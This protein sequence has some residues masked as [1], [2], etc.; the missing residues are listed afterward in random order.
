MK[1]LYYGDNLHVLRDYIKDESVDLIYLDPP[2]NS[3]RDYNLL[4]K[5]PKPPKK[6]DGKS[7]IKAEEPQTEYADASI[8]AFED[9]WHWGQQAED[10][11]REILKCGNTDVA[12]LIQALR[13]FLKENDMM[14]YLVMMCNRLL[15]L[16]RVL[17]STGS[18]YLHCDPT[19]SHYLK[20]VL[21]GVFGKENYRNEISWRRSQPKSHTSV[22]FANCRDIILR[23][24]KSDKVVFNKVFGDHDESYIEQFYRYTDAD[25]R[26]Y[27]LGD[28]TNPNKNRPNLTYEF[29]G[30]TR[31][32]RWTKERM[33]KAYE[34]GLVYQS[35]PGTVPQ[36]KRYL[37]EMGGQPISDDWD[38]IE[39]LHGSNAEFMGYPTQK[40][41]VLLDRIISASSNE[42]DVVLDPF[43]GCGTAVHAAEKLKRQ[44]IGI[45]ITHLAVSLIEKRMKEAFPYLAN[46]EAFEIIGTPQDLG[47]ARDLAERDKHQ[48]QLWACTLVGAQPYKGG[49]KGADGGIDGVLWIEVGGAGK[50]SQTE[51]V[52]VQVKGGIHVNRANI[53][54]LKGDIDREKAAIGL[55]ITLTEPTQPMKT[56][57]AA[58]GHWESPVT[59]GDRQDFPRIQ[60][61][62]I[63]GLLSG[64]ERPQFPDLSRGEQTFK[65]AKKEKKNQKQ[66][67]LF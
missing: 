51:K 21:D 22:N 27:R 66:A 7:A 64:K 46:K 29:L 23:F 17:K 32:W 28:I 3:K 37:D 59:F 54:T 47:A 38:D 30:V 34:E 35:K 36:E 2:F 33:Q 56:E 6:V 8:T 52:I 49:K 45:D 10:E 9:T 18:L 44:W 53:A 14:A 15:E 1:K 60:I 12:E 62:T 63:E 13:A 55:F 67:D 5:T 61:L 50:S 48:F 24:S 57:A 20:I 11:F 65:K 40:P 39:H 41:V 25:G 19:A 4:F 16:H 26:R 58:A 43:C 31:V 42:G